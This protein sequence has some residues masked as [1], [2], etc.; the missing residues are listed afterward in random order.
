ME[1]SR[2]YK[3]LAGKDQVTDDV[4]EA[5]LAAQHRK[6]ES[7]FVALGVQVWGEFD[8]DTNT[9]HVREEPHPGDE[10]MLGLAAIQN[11]LKGGTVYAVETEKMPEPDP[12]ATVFRY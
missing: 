1:S 8:R 2:P 3:Q 7:S 12:L 9:I 5:I 11:I 4:T 6:V 10:D